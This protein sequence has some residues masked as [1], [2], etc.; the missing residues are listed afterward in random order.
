MPN[1][2]LYMLRCRNGALYTGI[3]TDVK[4]RVSEHLAG[5]SKAARYTRQFAPVRLVYDT[6]IGDMS[7]ALKAE[8][9]V[10]KLSKRQKECIVSQ[11]FKSKDLLEFLK[12]YPYSKS[13]N[14]MDKVNIA[15]K[16]DLFNEHWQPKIVGELNDSY[17]KLARL[18]GE[19]VWH[20]HDI[21]DELFLVIKGKLT[22]KLRDGDLTL[23]EGEFVI[24]PRGVEHCPYAEDE[25]QVMLLE[26]KST[27]NTGDV[28]SERTV[29]SQWI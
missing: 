16:F 27:V 13:E 23:N 14:S 5:G 18:Q 17:V 3:C 6:I 12:I 21:E 26:Q 11:G 1:W 2:S 4:R 24:I 19:F 8:R 20:K 29:E 15:Q 10:K 7:L 28:Q 22:I 9:R 25:V